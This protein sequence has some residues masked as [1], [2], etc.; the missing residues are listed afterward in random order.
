MKRIANLFL[1]AFTLCAVA[2]C[3]QAGMAS[4]GPF[5]PG[6][7][8]RETSAPVTLP[9]ELKDGSNSAI[10]MLRLVWQLLD[11]PNPP[12]PRIL[13]SLALDSTNNRALLFG[14]YNSTTGIL[15]DLWSTNGNTWTQMY[16]T[17]KPIE[18]SGASMIYDE[19]RQETILF[20]GEHDYEYLGNTWKY[21]H[22]WFQQTPQVSPPPR[23]YACMA[24][25]AARNK[26]VLF[27]GASPIELEIYSL[28]DTWTWD[29]IN[30]QQ[31]FPSTMPHARHRANM[32]YD[33]ARQTTVLFGGGVG[34][35]LL[36]DTWIWDG[37]T[38]IEQHPLHS[39]PARAD[40]GMAYD[41]V[42]EQVILF[43]GQAIGASTDTWSWDGQDWT[44][45]E[46]FLEPP[47]A[48]SRSIGLSA[49]S[50]DDGPD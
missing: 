10:P 2:A 20:G 13:F 6:A 22:N 29:G 16:S 31:Q 7:L 41:N 25:D 15:N 9:V 40:F 24:Y 50:P 43:G 14:G 18:R 1:I 49:R 28:N 39:P 19:A 36:N 17:L 48:L 8:V 35:G 46:T 4:N 37:M 42:R 32:V 34:G 45:L 26:T 3:T 30:W 5:E 47:E 27:G 33:R 23:A 44:Q 21:V 11:I 12:P 38:W